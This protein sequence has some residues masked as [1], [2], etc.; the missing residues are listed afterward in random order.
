MMS[1][2]IKHWQALPARNRVGVSVSLAVFV[3]TIVMLAFEIKRLVAGF[4]E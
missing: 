3:V 2:W 4:R 1:G